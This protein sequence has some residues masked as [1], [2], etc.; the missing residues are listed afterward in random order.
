MSLN[1]LYVTFSGIKH[2]SHLLLTNI[3]VV[4]NF[5]VSTCLHIIKQVIMDQKHAFQ[6]KEAICFSAQ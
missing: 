2:V 3:E 6:Q 4:D 1:E 5:L